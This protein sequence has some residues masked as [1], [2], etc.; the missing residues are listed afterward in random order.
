MPAAP[1]ARPQCVACGPGPSTKLGTPCS[2]GFGLVAPTWPVAYGGLDI[3]PA[4][5]RRIEREHAPYNLGRLNPL[6]LNRAAPALFAYGTDEQCAGYLP[7]IVRNESVVP[8]L[9]RAGGGLRPRVARRT[10]RPRR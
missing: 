4:I 2:R 3:P 1:V 9:E 10:G 6:G 5:A 7:P 8:A